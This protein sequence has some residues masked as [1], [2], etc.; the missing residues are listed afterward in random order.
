MHF[1]GFGFAQDHA[2]MAALFHGAQVDGL[3]VLIRDLQ[4]KDVD[5]EFARGGKVLDPE[6]DVAEA[7]DVERRVEI[8]GRNGHVSVSLF[9]C[10]VGGKRGV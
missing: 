2:V 8:G 1:A 6:H 3:L 5:I 4:A 10:L 9:V 7:H